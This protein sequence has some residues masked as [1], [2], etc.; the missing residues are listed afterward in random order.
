MKG[1]TDKEIKELKSKV[2]KE[3]EERNA[4]K[5]ALEEQNAARLLNEVRRFVRNDS[6]AKEFINGYIKKLNTSE[7]KTKF[8]V[9]LSTIYNEIRYDK[10]QVKDYE[11]LVLPPRE[12]MIDEL[13]K[14]YFNFA[15]KGLNKLPAILR[16]FVEKNDYKRFK[17]TL[18]EGAATDNSNI[19]LKDLREYIYET[20]L[21][22]PNL[23]GFSKIVELMGKVIK[24]A[25]L[26]FTDK[27]EQFFKPMAQFFKSVPDA[28]ALLDVVAYVVGAKS[29]IGDLVTLKILEDAIV[30]KAR[31]A[32]AKTQAPTTEQGEVLKSIE[33]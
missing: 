22:A 16:E 2:I 28:E 10:I 9:V 30:N 21:L 3:L 15:K 29:N 8:C 4:E 17:E 31:A 12:V 11:K 14:L 1:A 6:D 18:D 27:L 13:D 26:S 5:K 32:T 25:S 24:D 20:P 23:E 7:E 19:N 33:R